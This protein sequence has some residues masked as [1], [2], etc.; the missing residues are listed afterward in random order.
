MQLAAIAAGLGLGVHACH[1]AEATPGVVRVS[2][3]VLLHETYWAVVH[4]DMAR[5]ARVRAA[6]N[7]LSDRA[8]AERERLAGARV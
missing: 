5:S 8:T 2:D 4:V 6:L 1:S 7:F 3:E